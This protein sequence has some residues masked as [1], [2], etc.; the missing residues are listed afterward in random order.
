MGSVKNPGGRPLV[1]AEVRLLDSPQTGRT[2]ERGEYR[3]TSL[4]SGSHLLE[5]RQLGFAVT[6]R[7]VVLVDGETSRQDVQFDRVVSLDSVS[8][9]AER[10]K[11]PEFEARRKE[12]IEGKFFD[13]AAIEKL[14]LQ[15]AADL[16]AILPGIYQV[17][18]GADIVLMS[19]RGCAPMILLD[20][21]EVAIRQIPA[22][23]IGAVEFYPSATSAP[24]TRRTA[25]GGQALCGTI[26]IWSRR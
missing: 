11:Y 16:S 7:T 25:G 13:E 4:A 20:D 17:G 24:M 19:M 22:A 2:D 1:G 12:A 10:S 15:S 8:V 3:L 18:R 6:R 26:R 14:H 9:V 5:I 23:I 21:V